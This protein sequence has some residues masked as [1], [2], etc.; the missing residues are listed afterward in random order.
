MTT[1]PKITKTLFKLLI[2][3]I[4]VYLSIFTVMYY[5]N[6]T[7]K[8]NENKEIRLIKGANQNIIILS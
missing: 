3:S 5:S 1:R 6:K 4:C 2:M 7:E 8:N